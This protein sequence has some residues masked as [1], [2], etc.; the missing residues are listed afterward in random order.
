M[1]PRK[2]QKTEVMVSNIPH[3][4]CIG[5]K[6]HSLPE[7]LAPVQEKVVSKNLCKLCHRTLTRLSK[8]KK[9]PPQFMHP[10]LEQRAD[11]LLRHVFWCSGVKDHH[12]AHEAP[13]IDRVGNKGTI[14]RSC[15]LIRYKKSNGE[16]N[17]R[18]SRLFKCMKGSDASKKRAFDFANR[19]ELIDFFNSC[20]SSKFKDDPY[21]FEDYDGSIK[22]MTIK[23]C[24]FQISVDRIS[25]NIGHLKNNCRFIPLF[26]NVRFK[27]DVQSIKNYVAYINTQ[28]SPTLL[29]NTS[30]GKLISYI[31]SRIR[32][33]QQSSV[34]RGHG[35]VEIDT[36][37][38]LEKLSEQNGKCSRSGLFMTIDPE[39]VPFRLSIDRIDNGIGYTNSNIR[40]VCLFLNFCQRVDSRSGETSTEYE[41]RVQEYYS[42]D[43]KYEDLHLLYSSTSAV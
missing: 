33:C 27:T 5:S 21:A 26:M 36:S 28:P 7:H 6:S 4:L 11:R 15:V 34:H 43:V 42:M 19:Q 23:S 10:T 1:P 40:L 37:Y 35:K 32:H 25:D 22:Q 24:A 13:E 9:R 12:E 16:F 8:H 29:N 38:I 14:C 2:K 17:S 39:F 18:F 41:K 31:N 20:I 3:F 30:R